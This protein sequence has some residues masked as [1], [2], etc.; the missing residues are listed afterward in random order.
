MRSA[1]ATDSGPELEKLS[2][3]AATFRA[4]SSSS[5]GSKMGISPVFS[6][7]MRSL[8]LSIQVTFQPKS[9]KHAADTRP[10]YPAPIMQIFMTKFPTLPLKRRDSVERVADSY[11]STFLSSA[12][13]SLS[14]GPAAVSSK[15]A[16]ILE[17]LVRGRF[18]EPGNYRR[19]LGA[20]TR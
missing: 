20:L 9:A 15:Q 11:K 4:T 2:R 10:T 18:A 1:S 17:Q 19:V 6:L 5:P 12:L 7:S 8:S 13:R 14:V 16:M 3:P